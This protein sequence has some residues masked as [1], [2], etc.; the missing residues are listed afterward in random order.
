MA[1]PGQLLSQSIRSE[2]A[3]DNSKV[4]FGTEMFCDS[5]WGFCFVRNSEREPRRK[6]EDDAAVDSLLCLRQQHR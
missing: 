6:R 2:S 1:D 4:H 5:N 3:T